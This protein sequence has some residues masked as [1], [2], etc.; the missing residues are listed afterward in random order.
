MS[1]VKITDVRVL[2]LVGVAALVGA[3]AAAALSVSADTGEGYGWRHG[4]CDTEQHEAVEAAIEAGNYSEWKELMRDRGRIASVVTAENFDT[5]AAMHEAMEEGDMDEAQA[6][7]EE[8]GLGLRLQDGSGYRGGHGKGMGMQTG[9]MHRGV[10]S[11]DG[12]NNRWGK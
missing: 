1:N 12:I 4:D 10:G 3:G 2:A 11:G 6:L 7:R 5:F 8:L 9:N